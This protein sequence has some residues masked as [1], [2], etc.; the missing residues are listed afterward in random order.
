MT[1]FRRLRNPQ[2]GRIESERRQSDAVAKMGA[3]YL[4]HFSRVARNNR[5]EQPRLGELFQPAHALVRIDFIAAKPIA[6]R[7]QHL[8]RD[9]IFDSEL[10]FEFSPET[11]RK[12]RRRALG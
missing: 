4:V 3:K 8:E 7:A 1:N 9:S 12:S 10:F 5:V 6:R 2:R 11:S